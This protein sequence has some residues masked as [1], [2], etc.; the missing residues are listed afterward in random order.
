MAAQLRELGRH[1]VQP[2]GHLGVGL[3]ERL[4]AHEE[5]EPAHPLAQL[6]RAVE[7]HAL[8]AGRALAELILAGPEQAV[9][10]N[11]V[12][13][14]VGVDGAGR[15]HK[16][17]LQ[18]AGAAALA[19]DQ[20]AHQPALLPPVPRA[21]SLSARPCQHLLAHPVR[22]LG[23]EQAVIH[24]H[25]L[26]PAPGGME[27]T[28][29]LAAGPGAERV[30]ELVAVAP[31]LDGGDDRLELEPL[32]PADPLQRLAHEP[33]LDLELTLVR[34]HLPGG[35][36]VVGERRDAVGRRL[37]DLDRPR[38]G[39][40]ALGLADHRPHAVARHRSGHEHDVALVAG[41]AVAAVGERVDRQLEHVAARGADLGGGS[42]HPSQD[43]SPPAAPRL[44]G[45]GQPS[46]RS[47]ALS[48][49]LRLALRRS[50]SRTWRSS[51]TLSPSS[52]SATWAA[53]R[54]S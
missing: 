39:V 6:R 26:V 40:R 41:D 12:D 32:E 20:V 51:A 28:H 49:V 2:L 37:D 53:V 47:I 54:S 17:H 22:A 8:T 29:E 36:R 3:E 50:W 44:P 45:R 24:R 42:G 27:A 19:H 52:R 18:L 43:D 31:L 11:L 16:P 25:D 33:G 13:Q 21:Q 38:L 14:R 23:G 35:A 7:E 48:T 4:R 5:V 15:G 10:A 9:T 34:E 46:L 30:L 1:L